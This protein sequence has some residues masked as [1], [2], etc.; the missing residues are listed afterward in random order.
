MRVP[1]DLLNFE[2][3]DGDINEPSH[4]EQIKEVNF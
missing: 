4:S 3:S 1:L 2:P